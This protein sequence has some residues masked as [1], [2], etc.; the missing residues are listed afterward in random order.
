M[1]FPQKLIISDSVSKIL[2]EYVKYL[3]NY[4]YI[5]YQVFVEQDPDSVTYYLTYIQSYKE[6]ERNNPSGYIKINN[7]LFLIYS[8]IDKLLVKDS[9][10]SVN[11]KKELS[12]IE[13]RGENE[14][15]SIFEQWPWSIKYSQK[16]GSYIIN[17]KAICRYSIWMTDW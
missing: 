4:K 10:F 15:P 17:K 11:L 6:L 5:V 1:F 2:K 14:S 3:G 16:S 13:L 12:N 7:N 8:G 9:I